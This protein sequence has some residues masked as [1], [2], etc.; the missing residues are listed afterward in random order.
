[1]R[2]MPAWRGAG[3]GAEDGSML[4][5][6]LGLVVLVLMVFALGWDASNWFLGHRALDDLADGAAV[7]A[8]NDVDVPAYYASNGAVVRIL[9]SQAD[10][11][12]AG[13]L[14]DAAGDSG[15]RGVRADPVTVVEVN[16]A[17]QVAVGCTRARRW[18]AWPTCGWSHRRWR[19]RPRRR[20][21]S[22]L[23]ESLPDGKGGMLVLARVSAKVANNKAQLERDTAQVRS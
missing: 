5:L 21:R 8:A 23:P 6:L 1:M 19:G 12:V 4:I 10:A 15:I 3:T 22:S 20:R 9:L 16:G 18:R 2:R 11:T 17:P 7:A 14:S 13:Y